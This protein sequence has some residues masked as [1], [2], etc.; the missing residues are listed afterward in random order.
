M[1]HVPRQDTASRATPD[2]RDL[3]RT[4]PF[5]LM[6]IRPHPGVDSTTCLKLYYASDEKWWSCAR[7][8]ILLSTGLQL[9]I[10][11]QH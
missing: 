2:L 9:L 8:D 7:R 3:G 11:M 1:H 4:K 10:G 6:S 5:L